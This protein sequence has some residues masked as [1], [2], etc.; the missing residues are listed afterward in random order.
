[1]LVNDVHQLQGMEANLSGRYALSR[2]IDAVE[3]AG[4]HGGAG[5]TPI[6]L[7]N[8]RFEG[9]LDGMNH[10][11]SGLT[12]HRPR[13]DFV[14][15][16][17][18]LTGTVRN[19]G[20]EN[21]QVTANSHAGAITGYNGG[22]LNNVYATGT[23]SVDVEPGYGE[24]ATGTAG[25]LAGSNGRNGLIKDAYSLVNVRGR[26]ELGGIAGM[27]EGVIDSVYATGKVGPPNFADWLFKFGGLVGNNS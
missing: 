9:Q 18:E 22:I 17:S 26:A 19:L 8:R 1:M 14:G 3:T 16:F 23:V 20:L 12:I 6:G 2:D 21:V 13:N 5:F 25:G 15:L 4:W 10:V 24:Q 27:N 11:I 7:G